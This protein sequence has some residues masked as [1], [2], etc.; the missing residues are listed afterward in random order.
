MTS[1]PTPT[2]VLPEGRYSRRSDREADRRL[3]IAAVV[4]G[5]L[6]LGLVAWL[7]GSYLLRATVLNGS[8]PTFQPV[9]AHE[10]QLQLSVHKNDGTG[11][12][13][14]VRSQGKDGSVVGQYDFPV[15]AAGSSYTQVVA[16]KTTDWG[17]TAELLGC[18]PAK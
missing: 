15:P 10:V 6:F 12:V 5:V 13:C 18:T 3:R 16:L 14:T 1:S 17:T 2:Q 11:G 4:C 9:S 7:G 8:V